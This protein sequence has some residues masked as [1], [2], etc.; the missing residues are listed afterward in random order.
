MG[1]AGHRHALRCA[2]PALDNLMQFA[3]ETREKAW[4]NEY[5]DMNLAFAANETGGGGHPDFEA[6][7]LPGLTPDP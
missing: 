5:R 7:R 6:V 4:W 1:R 2:G 3:R